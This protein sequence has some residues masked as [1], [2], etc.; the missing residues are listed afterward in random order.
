MPS[1]SSFRK[2]CQRNW[3]LE[4]FSRQ[5]LG[6]ERR[7]QTGTAYQPRIGFK[8]GRSNENWVPDRNWVFPM[9]LEFEG[10]SK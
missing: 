1:E 6:L 2:G 7:C 8:N 10:F 5:E 9:R 3:T 4:K